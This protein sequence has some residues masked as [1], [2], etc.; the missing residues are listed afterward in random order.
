MG[1]KEKQWDDTIKQVIKLQE[2]Y[3]RI[4]SQLDRLI[5]LV[6]MLSRVIKTIKETVDL[7]VKG[8]KNASQ[9]EKEGRSGRVEQR[10]SG[11]DQKSPD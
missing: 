3:N 9:K 10:P 7:I 11:R 6:G 1:K 8:G 4:A 5:G 2:D